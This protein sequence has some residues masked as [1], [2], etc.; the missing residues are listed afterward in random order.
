MSKYMKLLSLVVVLIFLVAAAGCGGSSSTSGSKG[1]LVIAMVNPLSGDSAT[2]GVSHKNG[3]ELAREEINKAGGIKGQQIE[4]LF[5]DDAGDPKQAAAGAQKFADQKNVMAIVGSCLSS[6][7]L[8]MVPITDKAKLPHSVVSSSTPKLSGMSKYF[9]RM[10]V[11]DAQVG[12]LMGDLIAQKLGAK[13]VA[14]LY[15]NNDYGK[16]LTAAIEETL[17][18]HGVTVVSNQAYLATDKDY[19]ALLTGIKAQGVD[20]LAVAGTYTDG[21]LITKQ[22]REL[23]LTIPIVGGTG[24]YSPKFVEIA[25]KA[26]EGAI[27]LGA[28]VASNPDPAVQN[29]VKKYK[30]KYNMEP[31]TFAALGYD[32]MY[33]LAEAMKKAAEKGAIT[34][35]NIRDAMAQ[36]NYKGITGTVTFNDQGD[37]VRPYLYI[38]VKDGKFVLYQ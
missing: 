24:F 9:F 34:R 13:K 23:G 16:G 38:T 6:N 29:F 3:M 4:I 1:N 15:P 17:K 20:A 21:G 37:W 19:S 25:G 26:A 32:Q 31:D 7:T 22:A 30:E 12:I 8:A 33:V 11:Q 5:H 2:Y 27:F 14:I 36:T 35:E 28:F 10:A 18:K